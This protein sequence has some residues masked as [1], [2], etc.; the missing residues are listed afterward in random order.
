MTQDPLTLLR[1][2]DP[3]GQIQRYDQAHTRALLDR[4]TQA[5]P[6]PPRSPAGSRHAT[7]RRRLH[8]SAAGALAAA[9]LT[10]GAGVAYAVFH[11]SAGSALDLACAAGT[12]LQQF[13][14]GGGVDS[15]SAISSG[16]PVAD[17]AADYRRQDM[18]PP[19]LRGYT[20]GAS[21]ISVVPA[22][23]PVP[24]SWQPLPATFRTDTARL[25]LAERLGDIV[26][27]PQSHCQSTETVRTYVRRQ[28]ADLGLT[29]WTVTTLDNANRADGVSWCALAF[30]DG[31]DN[32]T[33]D[34][35]GLPGPAEGQAPPTTPFGRLLQNLRRD[36][37]GRCL[38][39]PAAQHASRQAVTDAGL[40]AQ[41]AQITAFTDPAV[42]CTRVYLPEA[43]DVEITLQGPAR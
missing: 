11:H 22:A 10:S 29:G 37:D 32:R 17:C 18:T 12:T 4:I 1:D 21:Y 33:V 41:D 3:A 34:I 7:R 2:A 5:A 15:Y 13:Q 35:Q 43:G 23:W 42:R 20:T 27:G 19:P 40:S 8:R 14:H 28:L 16:D 26:A 36:V 31:S 39:L 38:T 9:V 6:A 24:A 30:T 25:E